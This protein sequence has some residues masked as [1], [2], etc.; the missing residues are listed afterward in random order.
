M[1]A[2]LDWSN[3]QP[4]L[5]PELAARYRDELGITRFLV[6]TQ[7]AGTFQPAAAACLSAQIGLDA[8]RYLYNDSDFSSQIQQALDQIGLCAPAHVRYLDLDVED[9]TGD[10]SGLPDRLYSAV[11]SYQGLTPLRIYSSAGFWDD[12]M[13]DDARIAALGIPLR[14]ADWTTG[15][16]SLPNPRM[17]G[18]TSCDA[19]QY[20]GGVTT[21]AGIIASANVC[22]DTLF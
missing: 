6:Q 16:A 22:A 1:H 11:Q 20:S 10:T 4:T 7:F 15:L 8:V 14:L 18:W 9:E 12:Y 13:L 21:L 19:K 3:F 2:G 17:G 5:T